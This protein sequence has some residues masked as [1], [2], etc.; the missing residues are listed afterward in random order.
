MP[1]ND[2][3]FKID[4]KKYIKQTVVEQV[5]CPECGEGFLERREHESRFALQDGFAMRTSASKQRIYTHQCTSC[6]TKVQLDDIYPKEY[7]ELIE[8]TKV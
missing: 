4:A 7:T 3:K 2:A 5:E 6:K 8:S 1:A